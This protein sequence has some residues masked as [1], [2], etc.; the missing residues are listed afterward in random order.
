MLARQRRIDPDAAMAVLFAVFLAI[1][2][3]VVSRRR[4]FQSDLTALLFGRI[5]SVDDRQLIDDR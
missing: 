2:V 4:G 3:V 1:G 5:L